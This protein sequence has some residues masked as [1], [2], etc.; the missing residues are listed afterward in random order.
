MTLRSA[1]HAVIS[2]PLFLLLFVQQTTTLKWR[3]WVSAYGGNAGLL[4]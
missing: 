1:P 3:W 2:F 4:A